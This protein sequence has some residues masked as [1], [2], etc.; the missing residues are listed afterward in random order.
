MKVFA[1][2]LKAHRETMVSLLQQEEAEIEP[3]QRAVAAYQKDLPFYLEELTDTLSEDELAKAL[4]DEMAF[5]KQATAVLETLQVHAKE[6]LLKVNK[7]K[8][9][10]KHY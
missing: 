2:K 8:K 10:R 5:A 7:G 1:A 4:Q 3:L 9:A 6:S